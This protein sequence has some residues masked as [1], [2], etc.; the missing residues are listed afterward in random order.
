MVSAKYSNNNDFY[1]IIKER[2]LVKTAG[3]VNIR[4]VFE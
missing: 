2:H 4:M 3:G 1:E